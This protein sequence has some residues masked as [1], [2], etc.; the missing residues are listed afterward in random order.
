MV[1]NVTFEDDI[2][3]EF[4]VT[5]EQGETLNEKLA[6]RVREVEKENEVAKKVK[7]KERKRT[8]TTKSRGEEKIRNCR[9]R[10]NFRGGGSPI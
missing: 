9:G 10:K 7:S 3:A 6:K 8:T 4:V 1:I 5:V 2:L